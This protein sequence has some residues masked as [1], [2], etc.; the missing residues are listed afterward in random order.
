ML[1]LSY[2]KENKEQVFSIMILIKFVSM[3][4]MAVNFDFSQVCHSVFS[5]FVHPYFHS[6]FA[7]F[8]PNTSY[9]CAEATR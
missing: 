9:R 2:G 5:A 7:L 1:S 4:C 3:V 6:S 8:T